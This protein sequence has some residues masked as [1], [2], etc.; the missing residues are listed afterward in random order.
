MMNKEQATAFFKRVM[1][2]CGEG[3]VAGLKTV[4]AS[5]VKANLFG[6]HHLDFKALED[7]LQYVKQHE[8]KREYQVHDVFVDGNKIAVRA[9]F[10]AQDDV[11]GKY[12]NDLIAIYHLNVQGQIEKMFAFSDVPVVY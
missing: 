7:R 1:D 9:H 11:V 4:C 2:I 6:H 10:K 3:D 8:R 5:N 12:D